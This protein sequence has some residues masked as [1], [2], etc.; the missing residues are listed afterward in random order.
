MPDNTV[1]LEIEVGDI[2]I[3]FEGPAD[4]ARQD[5][6]PLIRGLVETLSELEEDFEDEE[7]DEDDKETGEGKESSPEKEADEKS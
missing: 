4:F 1:K 7:E 2:D 5:L 6:L 3:Q